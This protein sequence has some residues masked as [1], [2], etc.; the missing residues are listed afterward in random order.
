MVLWCWQGNSPWLSCCYTDNKCGSALGLYCVQPNQF[1]SKTVVFRTLAP[2]RCMI[3]YTGPK[4]EMHSSLCTPV[5][6]EESQSVQRPRRTLLYGVLNSTTLIVMARV[7]GSCTC[8]EW[9]RLNPMR[10]KNVKDKG[11]LV[12][13]WEPD[14]HPHSHPQKAKV[15]PTTG[16]CKEHTDSCMVSHEGHACA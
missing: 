6:S 2:Q 9:H 10:G 14:S 11:P 4:E 5:G 13:E 8:G 15:G 12:R 16:A 3:W 1:S 7:R